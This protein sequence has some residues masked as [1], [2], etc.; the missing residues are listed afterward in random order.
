LKNYPDSRF[1]LWTLADGYMHSAQWKKAIAT[2]Q[3]L[4]DSLHPLERNNGYNEVGLCKQISHCY[5]YM[6]N[7]RMALEWVERGLAVPLD[8][9]SK[10]R[11]K[12][13]LDRFLT[14][15]ENLQKQLANPNYKPDSTGSNQNEPT[16][17]PP[18]D[19]LERGGFKD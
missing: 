1:Y 6:N 5:Q 4:Y 16:S 17:E 18:S 10:E 11:R 19:Q 14:L 9:E 7:P 3:K 15:R 8:Q 2:F 13:D 12:K